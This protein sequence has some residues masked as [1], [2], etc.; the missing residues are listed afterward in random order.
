MGIIGWIKK[1]YG[2]IFG[3]IL[4]GIIDKFLSTIGSSLVTANINIKPSFTIGTVS[5]LI[6]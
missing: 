1:N 4:E 2:R 3:K 6:H 5:K